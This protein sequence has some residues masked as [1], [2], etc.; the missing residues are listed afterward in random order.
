MINLTS[1]CYLKSDRQTFRRKQGEIPMQHDFFFFFFSS[2]DTL[3]VVFC[4]HRNVY[5]HSMCITVQ[6]ALQSD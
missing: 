5:A 2:E 6:Y 3:A 1:C 4:A